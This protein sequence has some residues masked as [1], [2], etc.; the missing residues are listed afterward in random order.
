MP[1]VASLH[2]PVSPVWNV[3]G[4]CQTTETTIQ[5]E[6][7]DNWQV[8]YILTSKQKHWKTTKQFC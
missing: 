5:Y 6:Y 4:K 8:Q 7:S 3:K 1:V 2:T